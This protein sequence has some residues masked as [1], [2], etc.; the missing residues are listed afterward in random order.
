MFVE[1]APKTHF[2]SIRLGRCPGEFFALVTGRLR[3]IL[4][5]DDG[6]F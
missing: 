3:A 1:G 6:L 5:M 4:T 2:L